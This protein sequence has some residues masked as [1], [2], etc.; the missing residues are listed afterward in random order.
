MKKYDTAIP[1]V[2]RMPQLYKYS[3]QHLPYKSAHRHN[4]FDKRQNHLETHPDIFFHRYCLMPLLYYSKHH[5]ANP[6]VKLQHPLTVLPDKND[7]FLLPDKAYAVEHL[8]VLAYPVRKRHSDISLHK[9]L[10]KKDKSICLFLMR[11]TKARD[12]EVLPNTLQ[13]LF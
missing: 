11:T 8:S 12:S 9:L 6:V 2:L 1:D 3:L 10:Q 7:S 5:A 13:L 4:F